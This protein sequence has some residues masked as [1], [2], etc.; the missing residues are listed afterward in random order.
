MSNEY[1]YIPGFKDTRNKP[2]LGRD[3]SDTFGKY[4][5]NKLLSEQK[6]SELN[7]PRLRMPLLKGLGYS[8]GDYQ[9]IANYLL[10][11]DIKVYET[12]K[13]EEVNFRGVYNSK[14][15]FVF[16]P[17]LT[18]SPEIYIGTIV[19]E[20][21]H[22]IQDL[23]K[24]RESSRDREVDAHFATALFMVL[25]RKEHLLKASRYNGYINLAK[26]VEGDPKFYRTGEFKR[27]VRDLQNTIT[28][29]YTWKFKDDIGKI[30]EFQKKERWDGI[31]V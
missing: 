6:I 25:S 17:E 23:K 11:K 2:L 31:G 5:A 12:K 28:T 10:S 1:E 7:F 29:E 14:N 24:W 13:T 8:S 27:R 15:Y 22:A 21:T 9:S 4:V 18:A 26:S 3:V 19:H 20:A 30:N 16:S